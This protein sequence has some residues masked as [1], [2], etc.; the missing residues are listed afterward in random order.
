VV[1]EV[2]VERRVRCE[3]CSGSGAEKGTGAKTCGTCGGRGQVVHSQGFF[4]IG[5]TCP[6]CRGEGQVIAK[7]CG[8]C[9]GSGLVV[10]QEKLQVT[11]PA[12]VDDGATLRLTGKGEPGPRGGSAGHLYVALRVESDDRWER[13]GD[14][15]VCEVGIPYAQAALG[16]SVTVPTLEGDEEIDVEP[17]TQPGA[18]LTLRGR[19]VQHVERH[20][21]G[22]LIVRFTVAVPRKLTA[23][24]EELLRALAAEEGF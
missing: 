6:A 2:P 20:G 22:D 23:R 1:K 13:D 24:H 11:I 9:R 19:G 4:M 18:T 5:A 21:R 15:L 10:R 17:G 8:D 12:G 16:G 7:P 3:G 14:D